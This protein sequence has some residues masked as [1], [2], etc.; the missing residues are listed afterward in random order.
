MNDPL[1]DFLQA[2]YEQP[3]DGS[4]R[5]AIFDK[6]AR[7]VGRSRWLRRV[8]IAA[9]LAACF[10]VGVG[11]GGFSLS[12]HTVER[13]VVHVQPSSELPKMEPAVV[14]EWK[15]FDAQENRA[16]FYLAA[17]RKYLRDS[18]DYDSALRCYRQALDLA[19]EEELA[20]SPEDD[21]LL[22]TLKQSRRKETFHA[23]VH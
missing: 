11:V 8:Y 6:T 20:P 14:Q 4:V 23:A 1:E 18:N 17:G 12:T 13:V 10:T 3:A 19:G 22:A 21:W 9:T 7:V 16:E 15:A 2:D 5:Q